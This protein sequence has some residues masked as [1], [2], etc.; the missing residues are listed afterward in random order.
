MF[1][2]FKIALQTNFQNLQKLPLFYVDIDRE[3]IWN[4]YLSGFAEDKRQEYN[5]N[6][7]KS[8]LRQFGGIVTIKDNKKVSIWDNLEVEDEY[9]QSVNNLRKYI[10]SLPI[11]DIFLSDTKKAG[12][13]KNYDPKTNI[14]WQHFFLGIPKP[15]VNTKNLATVL[16]SNRSNKDVFKR[17]LDEL[18]IDATE[19][20]L[21]LIA[22]NSLYRGKE[23]EA[24]LKKFL[25]YQKQYKDIPSDLKDN[26]CWLHSLDNHISKI[27]NSSIGTL[28]IDLSNNVALDEAVTK[29]EKVVAPSNYKRPTSLVTPKMVEQA[30]TKLTEL[31]LLSALERR[32]ANEADLKVNDVLFIDKS[33]SIVDVFDELSKDTIVNVR[34]LT[35]VE[36]ISIE[37]FINNIVPTVFSI[38]VLPEN[39]HLSNFVTLITSQDRNSSNLFKWNNNFSWS[40]TGGVTDSIKEQVKK[41]GGNIDAVLRFSI[42]WNE[43]GK[44]IVDLDDHAYEPNGKHIY[45]GTHKGIYNKTPMSGYLDVD[46]IDPND[47]GVENIIWTDISKMKYGEYRFEVNN[48]NSKRHSGFKAQIAFED[49]V[50]NYDFP[51]HFTGTKQ[52]GVVSFSSKG[53]SIDAQPTVISK[54]KWDV[55]TYQWK[56]VSKL[57]LSPN[58]WEQSVGNK[59]YIFVL[60]GCKSDETPRP[61]YNE[62]LKNE[63][64][65]HRKVF[66]VLGSKLRIADT[67]NQLSGLGFSETQR[68][69][70]FVRVC[71]KFERV[72]KVVF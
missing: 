12:T 1:I 28:L 35:K 61:F 19:T 71:G 67:N 8:F 37:N 9:K 4:K 34:N 17:S 65:E 18:T 56:R 60:E 10:H 44:S 6:C 55:N 5:C 38:E 47:I 24:T 11:T 7:C 52:V 2:N 69:H 41:A 43:D 25:S 54:N 27:R 57:M 64:M 39:N 31:G 59:H 40:Y 50:F 3:E 15:Y 29:F 66:E 23:F 14:T 26:Y 46:M 30:K 58:Y 33:T 21:E 48:F 36:E 72:L 68:N 63:F 32:Y 13:D 20:I 70:L 45:F 53:F 62:F 22:Q 51:G 42:I 16:S 49:Q